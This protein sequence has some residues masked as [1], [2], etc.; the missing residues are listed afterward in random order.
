MAI[1]T[2]K[3]TDSFP[4]A[5]LVLGEYN[6]FADGTSYALTLKLGVGIGLTPRADPVVSRAVFE[7]EF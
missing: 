7:V 4:A 5:E 2:E 3:L 1:Y 6:Q